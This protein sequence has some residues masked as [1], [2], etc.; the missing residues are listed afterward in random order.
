MSGRA[1]RVGESARDSEGLSA[2]I[3]EQTIEAVRAMEA[4]TG[5]VEEGTRLV[6]HTLADLQMLVQVVEDTAHAV[7]EQAVASDEIAR[8][9]HTVQRIAQEVLSSSA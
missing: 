3:K 2:T 5:E 7:Q 6:T 9:M 4:G 1:K 8:N